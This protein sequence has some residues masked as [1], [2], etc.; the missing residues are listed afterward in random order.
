MPVKQEAKQEDSILMN[1]TITF[2]IEDSEL[3]KPEPGLSLTDLLNQVVLVNKTKS[4][5]VERKILVLDLDETL[6]HTRPVH[7]KYKRVY[8]NKDIEPDFSFKV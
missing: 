8:K 6:V 7:K 3:E 5:G 2:F 4:S 1:E